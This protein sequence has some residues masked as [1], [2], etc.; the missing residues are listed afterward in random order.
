MGHAIHGSS[1]ALIARRSRTA[2]RVTAF[3]VVGILMAAAAVAAAAPAT[4]IL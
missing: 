4:I 1:R 3:L 2:R